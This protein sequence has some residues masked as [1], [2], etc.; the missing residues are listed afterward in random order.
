MTTA[1]TM[2]A[3]EHTPDIEL[4]ARSAAG[5]RIAFEELYEAHWPRVYSICLKMLGN[6]ADA[7]DMAQEIFIQLY[8]KI[9]TFRGESAFTTW[10]HRVA[11]NQVLMYLRKRR[12]SLED[13]AEPG[14]SKNLALAGTIRPFIMP[15]VDR[16]ALVQAISEISPSY[17]RVFV[18]HEI[19]GYN[20]EEIAQ[21]LGCRVGTSKSQLHKARMKLRRILCKGPGKRSR[22]TRNGNHLRKRAA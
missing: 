15:I 16:I 12:M 9:D 7:E 20:H 19:E 6:I 11:V 8:R 18:L 17:R 13:L 21:M 3:I 22:H 10:L 5:D 1:M 2:R 14:D 4:A